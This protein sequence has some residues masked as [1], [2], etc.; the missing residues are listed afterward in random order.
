MQRYYPSYMISYHIITAISKIFLPPVR[1]VL[2]IADITAVILI[3]SEI[4][5]LMLPS[6]V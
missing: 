3:I 1:T 6:Y 4:Q 5:F 2:R